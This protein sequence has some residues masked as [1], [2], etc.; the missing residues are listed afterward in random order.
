[1]LGV[2]ER[3][4]QGW[5]PKESLMTSA[6]RDGAWRASDVGDENIHQI[7]KKEKKLT[8]GRSTNTAGSSRWAPEGMVPQGKAESL[9]TNTSSLQIQLSH[10]S[11]FFQF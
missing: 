6:V 1:M 9:P 5:P 10:R 11:I 8:L 3:F 2:D 4:G 7:Q